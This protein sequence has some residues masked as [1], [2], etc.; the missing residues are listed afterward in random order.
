MPLSRFLFGPELCPFLLPS[1]SSGW[2]ILALEP[3]AASAAVRAV[4]AAAADLCQARKP[5]HPSQALAASP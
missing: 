5:R 2:L 3:C 1:V 4:A